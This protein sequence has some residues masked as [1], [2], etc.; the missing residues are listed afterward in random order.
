MGKLKQ[1]IKSLINIFGLGQ[2]IDKSRYYIQ[3]FQQKGKI[4]AFKAAHPDLVLPEPFMI[5]ETFRLDYKRYL[6]SG[7]ADA[8]QIYEEVKPFISLEN[9]AVLDWGCGPGRIIRHFPNIIPSA[10]FYASDYNKEYIT[11]CQ[12][13]LKDIN[14]KA[15]QL[16]PPIP[17]PSNSIDFAYAISI[18]THLSEQ[19]HFDW[20]NEMHRLIK[21]GGIFYFTAHGDITRKNLLENELAQYDK[22]ELVERGNVKEGNRMFT[23]Y[24]PSAFIHTLLSGKFKIVKHR[25]GVAK[26]WGLEQDV[27]IV[28]KVIE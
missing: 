15:N 6:E 4:N 24:H 27:W 21:P 19:K 22:G 2:T 16:S 18:F 13:N 3:Y 25:K 10:E 12:Q 8:I 26:S 17:F 1:S 7:K 9:K 28:Q 14:F 20:I 5:Y 23:A 11:W